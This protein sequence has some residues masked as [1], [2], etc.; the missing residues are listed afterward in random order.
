M[1]G[2]DRV[3]ILTGKAAEAFIENDSRK[4]S[5][6]EKDYLDDAERF[7]LAHCDDK[8]QKTPL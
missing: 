5:E 2:S 3:H 4:L 8:N 1:E 7:Y 6:K